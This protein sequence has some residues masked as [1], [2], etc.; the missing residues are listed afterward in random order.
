MDLLHDY[1]NQSSPVQLSRRASLSGAIKQLVLRR[2]D[3]SAS[4]TP[5]SPVQ[6][7]KKAPSF[8]EIKQLVLRRS[9]RH[10]GRPRRMIKDT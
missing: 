4:H 2:L 7:S 8:D 9:D 5:S 10:R 6:P 3:R 1:Q